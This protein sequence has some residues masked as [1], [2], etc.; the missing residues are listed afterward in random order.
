MRVQI[1]LFA[2][3]RQYAPEGEHVFE[4]ELTYGATTGQLLKSL[5]I[6]PTEEKVIMVNGHQ[7]KEDTQLVDGDKVV[8]F[9]PMAGG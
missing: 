3:L 8:L 5:H 4:V 7:A 9:P 6:P 2:N 1:R